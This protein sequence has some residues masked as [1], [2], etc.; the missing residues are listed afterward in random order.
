MLNDYKKCC[1]DEDDMCLGCYR[2]LNDILEWA[3]YTEKKKSSILL[4]A[5]TLKDANGAKT[6]WYAFGS[7]Q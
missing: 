2:T 6:N 3:N 4:E 1:L 5:K 7:V